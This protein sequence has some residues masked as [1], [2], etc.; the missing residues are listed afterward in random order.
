VPRRHHQGARQL[1]DTPVPAGPRRSDA[2]DDAALVER[3]LD[4]QTLLRGNFLHVRRDTVALP[5]GSRATREYI[6]HPGAVVVVPLLDDGRL[7]MERQ[8]RYPVA[9]VILE[10]PAGKL[11]AG[12]GVLGCAERELREE[13]GYSAAEWAI[14]GVMHNAP[15]YA[16]EIIHL[17]FARG[18]RAGPTQL[19][20]GEFIELACVDEAE[21]ERL[22][23]SGG[24]TDVKTLV[25]ALWLS[26]WRRGLRALHWAPMS[27][28]RR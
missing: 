13:T 18:L 10:F 11:D 26:Q 9:Q 3:R 2:A 24:I 22:S 12:E 25:A 5:D 17:V 1:N 6:V 23:A 4:S 7:L 27:M 28:M 20:E 8:Y 21:L 19:D 14:G 15:A 16:T